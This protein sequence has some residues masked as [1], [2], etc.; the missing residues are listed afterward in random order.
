MF[1]V[2]WALPAFAA[3]PQVE[4]DA[5][6][7]HFPGRIRTG[8]VRFSQ[9]EATCR[10]GLI[11]QC[12]DCLPTNPCTQGV[13]SVDSSFA[14]CERVAGVIRWNCGSGCEEQCDAFQ[15][16][17]G[18]VAIGHDVDC[19]VLCAPAIPPSQCPP[20]TTV[21]GFDLDG[22]PICAAVCT[23]F[24]CPPDQVVIGRDDMCN[25]VC[26]PVP[27]GPTSTTTTTTTTTTN[28]GPT[29]TTTTSST[30]TTT[31]LLGAACIGID[32]ITEGDDQYNFW[33]APSPAT[34][35]AV[36]CYCTGACSPAS[37][38]PTLAD[39][40]GA[41]ISTLTTIVCEPGAGNATWY[42]VDTNDLDRL[43]GTGEALQLSIGNSAP[44]APSPASYD[45]FLLCA[46][47]TR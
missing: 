14:R 1:L 22:N 12:E 40:S 45:H 7:H 37:A 31:L 26:G 8:P 20:P 46:Q 10:D 18:Q 16:P 17:D 34:I 23:P 3:G 28:T 25:P 13:L 36:A 35:T 27:Q 9:L 43:L 39:G 42:P 33:V 11:V 6:D 47:Y 29:T 4:H 21:V 32:A 19:M 5:G 24:T 44:G 38:R 2:A 41:T 15:C 30:T